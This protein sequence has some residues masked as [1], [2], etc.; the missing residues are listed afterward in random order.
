MEKTPVLVSACLLG[1]A[2]RYD[3]K[4][5][6]CR[7]MDGLKGR[8]ALIPACPEQLGG[9]STPRPPAERQG[10]RVTAE[11]GADVT[12]QYERGA[13]QALQM[14]KY[15]GCR[16]A[17]LKEKS[18]SCGCGRI[19]DGTFSRTLTGGNGVTAELFL[20]EGIEV[21]GESRLE[22]LLRRL[23]GHEEREGK[24]DERDE[25]DKRAG[26]GSAEEI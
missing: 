9:L 26:A 21:Y 25:S 17:V 18:P 1:L 10:S 22:D 15:F 12:A 3:G 20:K 19:Y 24:C 13:A 5:K 16:Y 2:C 14:A 7:E 23:D 6:A 4:Q 8:C 11:N